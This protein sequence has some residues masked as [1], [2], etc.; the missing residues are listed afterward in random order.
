[1]QRDRKCSVTLTS[2]VFFVEFR[3]SFHRKMPFPIAQLYVR[4]HNAKSHLER[5]LAAYYLWE[6]SLKVLASTAIA[7]Y[8]ELDEHDPATEERLHSLARPSTGHWWEYIKLLV[9]QL[10]ET[11]DESFQQI[12]QTL[13]GPRQDGLPRTAALDGR[14][15][16][17]LEG[18]STSRH[19]VKLTELFDRMI[20]FRNREIG[21]GATGQQNSE[22]YEK[23]GRSMLLGMEE[24]LQKIDVLA[25]RD[26]LFIG[27]VKR[28]NSG[29]WSIERY[30]L[31]ADTA[32]RLDPLE[33]ESDAAAEIP[34]PDQIYLASDSV[35]SGDLKSMRS[36][37]PLLS[38]DN[39]TS[40]VF[41]L[42]GKRGKK[43]ANYLCYTSGNVV[44]RDGLDKTQQELLSRVLRIDVNK[45][46]VQAWT[47]EVAESDPKDARINSDDGGKYLDEFLLKS[48]IGRGG[49]GEVYRAWQPSLG[50]E[51]ALKCLIRSGD[52]TS[53]SRFAREIRALGKVEHPHLV[54]IFTAGTTEEGQ[55]FYAMELIEGADLESVSK[56]LAGK[57]PGEV[58]EETW[59]GVLSTAYEESLS[60][61][62]NVSE[63]DE[64]LVEPEAP[65][66]LSDSS[67]FASELKKKDY[68][69]EVVEYIRQTAEAV[70]ALH[71][72]GVVHRDIKPGNIMLDTR[73]KAVLMDLGLAKIAL[74]KDGL[75][76]TRQF[77]GTI[78]YA[79]P[80]QVIAA[81]E[82]DKRSDIYSLGATL[83]ELL[84][85]RP[86]FSGSTESST[87][88][89]MRKIQQDDPPPVSS[90]NP[91]VSRDLS[92]IVQ[93][94]MEKNPDKRYQ[95]A[96][97]LVKDLRRY[98]NGE[99]VEA[100]PV[101]W[102][103]RVVRHCQRRPAATAAW[104]SICVLAIVLIIGFSIFFSPEKEGLRPWEVAVA[105]YPGSLKEWWFDDEEIS[106]QM[107]PIQRKKLSDESD[108]DHE[109]IYYPETYS[110]F[111]DQLIDGRTDIPSFEPLERHTVKRPNLDFHRA[112][113]TEAERRGRINEEKKQEL[114]ATR[115]EI[116]S[117]TK[118]L[119]KVIENETAAGIHTRAL[120]N[121]RLCDLH[122]TAE[123][124]Q[125][126]VAKNLPDALQL[127]EE[128]EPKK[129]MEESE[130]DFEKAVQAYPEDEPMRLLCEYDQ[131]QLLKLKDEQKAAYKLYKLNVR[132][133]REDS[134]AP[135]TNQY[136]FKMF[137][138]STLYDGGTLC[139]NLAKRNLEKSEGEEV[140]DDYFQR[141][142]EQYFNAKMLVDE[143]L[144]KANHSR[145]VS[146]EKILYLNE[147][148]I[149]LM[150]RLGLVY[151]DQWKFTLAM[152]QFK[153]AIQMFTRSESG[154]KL[155]SV[156]TMSLRD[157]TDKKTF[158][159]R[160][161]YIRTKHFHSM[162]RCYTNHLEDAAVSFEEIITEMSEF[163]KKQE[164]PIPTE[165][166]DDKLSAKEIDEVS[167]QLA[168]S[169]ERGSECLQSLSAKHGQLVKTKELET[170]FVRGQYKRLITQA[171]LGES[172]LQATAKELE[173]IERTSPPLSEPKMERDLLRRV[174]RSI[175][176]IAADGEKR[177]DAIKS[178][179]DELADIESPEFQLNNRESIVTRVLTWQLLMKYSNDST[180]HE[181]VFK[182]LKQ[183][184]CDKLDQNDEAL[185][186]E[187]LDL[188]WDQMDNPST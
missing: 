52:A 12:N 14:L 107:L 97:E 7:E 71:K 166:D 124:Q 47:E 82:V 66:E 85:L 72:V 68:V 55:G 46:D 180:E 152:K 110:T 125:A 11:G 172:S 44:H 136:A 102:V 147:V 26:L 101:S 112:T 131:I 126:V 161:E 49:M 79:S 39:E 74:D 158:H 103:G 63:V 27:D 120:L 111:I 38:Y 51:V 89:I 156:A 43:K 20:T 90:I 29:Q 115:N 62:E 16:F 181:G 78:C 150:D 141:S 140:L 105:T 32:W 5:Y 129:F 127:Q 28:K 1:M 188:Y 25:G 142:E 93:K 56:H 174:A 10:A 76:R 122:I 153:N 41:F 135:W 173:E 9:P 70:H 144:E 151:M 138:V 148:K 18:K 116:E 45:D 132:L 145:Q 21:H 64:P 160:M 48:L 106:W 2:E 92:A 88:E 22:H 6:A 109:K 177:T 15:R 143:M 154:D 42:N 35:N 163:L 50:R 81:G 139:R 95:T 40:E 34:A 23:L 165:T 167:R 170:I 100:R 94:C 186:Y 4:G 67:I 77:V 117:V 73:G 137:R 146:A 123:K 183:L 134:K 96:K 8:A 108:A 133:R 104:T 24:L 57:H 178:L 3:D 164:R 83:W 128:Y 54:K 13:L 75:T 179:A 169:L 59:R 162:A 121:Y 176:D 86:P 130:R 98:Q 155:N 91:R 118:N 119:E 30:S 69:A 65:T 114:A 61:E 184:V 182:R 84:A 113:E 58:D 33:V 99:P 157:V 80:E 37:H 149:E 185:L 19:G 31:S 60:K 53:E 187:W 159:A 17:E 87:F 175:I 36:L 171:L 168:N